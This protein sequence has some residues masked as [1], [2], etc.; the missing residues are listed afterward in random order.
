MVSCTA[1]GLGAELLAGTAALSLFGTDIDLTVS[2]SLSLSRSVSHCLSLSLSVCLSSLSS[3][4]LSLSISLSLSLSLSL[5]GCLWIYLSF[6]S[7]E[8]SCAWIPLT[9]VDRPRR[10]SRCLAAATSIRWFSLSLSICLSLYHHLSLAV[11]L[12]LSHRLSLALRLYLSISFL[13][14]F[15]LG[16]H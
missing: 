15:M 6:L 16:Y 1:L 4:S 10:P 5:S 9:F 11:S 3:L 8:W 14:G 12:G 2:L 13:T 7:V